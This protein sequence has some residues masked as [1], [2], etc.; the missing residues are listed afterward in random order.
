MNQNEYNALVEKLAEEIIDSALE[1]EAGFKDSAANMG[2]NVAG[3]ARNVAGGAANLG[4]NFAGKAKN[5]GHT[6]ADKAK[7][8]AQKAK[9]MGK[10]IP[11]LGV[12]IRDK[13]KGY[14]KR[15]SDQAER[16]GQYAQ[17]HPGL[18][19]GVAG[20]AGLVAGGAIG[21]LA[22]RK[23][24]EK[25]AYTLQEG[26]AKMAASEEVYD[27]ALAKIAASEEVYGLGMAEAEAAVGILTELGIDV[28]ALLADSEYEEE[29]YDDGYGE[30]SDEE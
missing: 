16:A 2:R 27:D 26:L 15:F 19:A 21:S 13:A 22:Q 12:N 30:N 5:V 29:G 18:T 25:A 11:G 14:G 4:R 20:G 10:A 1:K 3:K 23:M 17:Q 8:A 24:S 28:D 9:D 6:V 7:D